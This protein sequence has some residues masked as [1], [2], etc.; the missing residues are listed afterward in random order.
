MP[1]LRIV[2]EDDAGE[3]AARKQ[4]LA[5]G[6]N[7][8][9][10][11]PGKRLLSGLM[12]C[13][14]CGGSMVIQGPDRGGQRII[15]SNHKEARTCNN[16][17]RYYVERIEAA[18]VDHLRAQLKTPELLAAYVAAYREERRALEAASRRGRA[19]LE[20]GL[21]DAKA[22]I[23]RIVDM[24]GAGILDAGEAAERL[25]PLRAD[26]DRYAAELATAANETNVIE[27]HPTAVNAFHQNLEM[28]HVILS[29]GFGDIPADLRN[30]FR[31][32]VE[33]V[34]IR[35][36]QAHE[37]YVFEVTGHLAPLLSDLSVNSM[38]AGEGL[39]PP[40]RGL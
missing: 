3:A 16:H 22:G 13:G 6:P 5:R 29:G 7:S 19:K 40:T 11:R 1:H 9:G 39:E 15:C 31:L 28:L 24:I 27:L 30:L 23:S 2:R 18:V 17:S 10:G 34:T 33:A 12:R 4:A 26:R 38:V 21:A 20:K 8:R 37:P 35:P 36:R 14:A 25:A 32:F